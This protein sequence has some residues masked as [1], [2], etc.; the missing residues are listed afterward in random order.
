MFGCNIYVSEGR[1]AK[2]L[3]ALEGVV[4]SS[5]GTALVKAFRDA[6]YHRTGFTLVS[7]A[8]PLLC[9]AVVALVG[10]ALTKIDLQSHEASHP[11][12][13]SVDHISCSPLC[14]SVPIEQAVE[15]A[16]QIG[17]H[18][19]SDFKV[20]V[21]TYG[22]ANSSA[23]KLADIRRQFGYFDGESKGEW[24]HAPSGLLSLEPEFGPSNAMVQSGIVCLGACPWVV[25]FNVALHTDDL[26][27]ARRV[28]KRV[29]ARGGGLAEVEAMALPH[30]DGIV[31]IACNLLNT[32]I[33]PQQ[34]VAEKIS[35]LA[36]EADLEVG[37]GYN[38]NLT[39][40]ELTCKAAHMLGLRS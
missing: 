7:P 17:R 29:S 38:T 13:G 21:Y 8:G 6:P 37:E 22:S 4:R 5:E 12:L 25:N 30:S 9:S 19:G 28:A 1:D 34:E 36:K 26:A 2:I 24:K 27:M 11:R 33:T 40:V 3:D 32:A 10:A 39:P 23:R 14:T 35:A 18:V 20:P 16:H 31:E 15:L